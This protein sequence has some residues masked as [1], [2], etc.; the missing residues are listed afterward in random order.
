LTVTFLLPLLNLATA[1]AEDA[2]GSGFHDAIRKIAE[3]R[4][5]I[6]SYDVTITGKVESEV[7]REHLADGSVQEIEK[8]VIAFTLKMVYDK[9]QSKLLVA[10]KNAYGLKSTGE[11]VSGNWR[12]FGRTLEAVQ[13]GGR[14]TTG[15]SRFIGT[16]TEFFDP[17][18]LGLCFEGEFRRGDP[19]ERVVANYLKWR[20]TYQMENFPD[21][22]VRFK[23]E[24]YSIVID[25]KRD[26]WPVTMTRSGP[27]KLWLETDLRLAN[28]HGHWLPEA[29]AVEVP[30]RRTDLMFDWHSVNRP[31]PKERFM[32]KEI[33]SR[34]G[35][36][37][38][39]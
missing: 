14:W 37:L 31:I 15:R 36:S 7:G 13:R 2:N 17:L 26:Q 3:A 27:G 1:V 33:E 4:S 20:D 16:W 21:G 12:V 19:W 29:G 32:R 22:K 30:R 23:D 28:V 6:K 39:D 35:L 9:E 5:R 24:Q 25:T 34:Y 38:G 18:A 10:R 8:T 11:V